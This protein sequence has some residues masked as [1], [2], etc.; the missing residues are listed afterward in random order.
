MGGD[1]RLYFIGADEDVHELAWTGDPASRGWYHG[2]L[3]YEA[4]APPATGSGMSATTVNGAPRLYYVGEQGHVHELA[5][6]TDE[7]IHS[8][9]TQSAGATPADG[10]SRL[11]ATS[12]ANGD[13]RV[14]YIAGSSEIYELAWDGDQWHHWNLT[15]DNP[16]WPDATPNSPLVAI[17][18]GQEPRVYYLAKAY[19]DYFVQELAWFNHS[20]HHTDLNELTGAFRSTRDDQLAAIT[21]GANDDP[22]IYY[23][24]YDSHIVELAWYSDRWHVDDLTS[25]VGSVDPAAATPLVATTAHL[26]PLCLLSRNRSACT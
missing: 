16:S 12:S 11:A 19:K 26:D 1:P 4:A 2:N 15:A 24:G 14:Y 6:I 7:W 20:W 3:S 10:D 13:P 21:V 5:W 17:T 18:A 25:L 9:V 8:D 22:R 23:L